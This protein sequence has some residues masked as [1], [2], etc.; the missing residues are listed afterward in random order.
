MN[1]INFDVLVYEVASITKQQKVHCAHS[2]GIK[3][4]VRVGIMFRD[5]VWSI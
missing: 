1:T 3:F 2:H 5:G 4:K